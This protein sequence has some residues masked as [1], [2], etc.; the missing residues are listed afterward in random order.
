MQL[1]L[2]LLPCSWPADAGVSTCGLDPMDETLSRRCSC[3]VF[4]NALVQRGCLSSFAPRTLLL[5]VHCGCS[6]TI[7]THPSQNTWEW[8]CL[9]VNECLFCLKPVAGDKRTY[10][11]Y[12]VHV[13]NPDCNF[14]NPFDPVTNFFVP[15]TRSYFNETRIIRII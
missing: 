4:L 15:L 5:F 11:N 8:L 7:A 10:V 9:Y 14:S 2:R 12:V 6:C 13:I 1:G 3:N